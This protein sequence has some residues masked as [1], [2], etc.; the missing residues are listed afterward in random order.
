MTLFNFYTESV[1]ISEHQKYNRLLSCYGELLQ[2]CEGVQLVQLVKRNALGGVESYFTILGQIYDFDVNGKS[3][4]L[5]GI[6]DYNDIKYIC[7]AA[8]F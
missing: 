4:I 8:L 7:S 5:I 6:L 1:P 3:E 2:E